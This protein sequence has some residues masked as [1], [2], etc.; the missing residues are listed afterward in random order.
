MARIPAATKD[1]IPAD[2]QGAFDEIVQSLGAVPPYGPGSVMIHVPEASRRATALNQYLRNDSSVSKKIQELAMLITAREMDCQHIWNA[3]AGSG[4]SAGLSDDVVD[5]GKIGT[6]TGSHQRQ[7]TSGSARRACELLGS[8][9][10]G[11]EEEE[12]NGLP[13]DEQAVIN[14]GHEILRSHHASRGAF[15]AI[16]EQFGRC[17]RTSRR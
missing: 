14:Y 13:E 7:H 4:R 6:N 9:G 16:L 2:Q 5:G 17:P 8:S 10:G 12:L 3:H 11:L 1:S 15:Q